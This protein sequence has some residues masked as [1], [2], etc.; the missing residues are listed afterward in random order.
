MEYRGLIIKER[1]LN[2]IFE[3]K[4]LWEIRS[5]NT[6]IRGKIFLIQSGTKM[7]LGECRIIDCIKL[8]EN[9]F[10]NNRSIHFSHKKYSELLYKTPY[11]WVIDEKSIKKY[12]QP[13][14]YEHP[15]GAIIWVNL[16][17]RCDFNKLLE[18]SENSG[19]TDC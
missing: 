5:S 7:I 13:V 9:M 16:E 17:N 8:D 14:Q 4:K 19:Y 2:K 1:P 15:S 12:E 3:H 11:A 18:Q 10:E 6:N